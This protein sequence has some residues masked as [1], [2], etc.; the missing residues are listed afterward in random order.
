MQGSN[1]QFCNQ[2]Y[3][4]L[5]F[6]YLKKLVE[7]FIYLYTFNTSVKILDVKK[8]LHCIRQM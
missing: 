6:I 4:Y 7:A 2:Y 8:F 1:L 5:K 3:Y